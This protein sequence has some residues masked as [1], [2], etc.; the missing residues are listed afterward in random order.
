MRRLLEQIEPVVYRLSYHLTYHQQD[1]EDI[2]QDVLYKVCTKLSTYHKQ[3]SFQTWV[4]TLVMNTF[5]DFCRKRRRLYACPLQEN[6]ATLSFEAAADARITVSQLLSGLPEIDRQILILRF[7]I[8]LSVKE[9]AEVM[10]ISEASV[11][12]KVFRLR[13]RLQ[14]LFPIG[15]EAL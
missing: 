11:K 1:A 14:V 6:E 7:Q 3:S 15:G 2:T 10:K 12:T 5:K 9:V 13:Q 4:Y 8:G